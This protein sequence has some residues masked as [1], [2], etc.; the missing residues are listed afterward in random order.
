[1]P[2]ERLSVLES[3][4]N[5]QYETFLRALDEKAIELEELRRDG[6]GIQV[7]NRAELYE[8]LGVDFD[9]IARSFR[10]VVD[11]TNEFLEQLVG[12]LREKRARV[13]DVLSGDVPF[14][15]VSTSDVESLNAVIRRHDE[16]TEQFQEKLRE[17]RARVEADSVSGNLDE[18]VRLEVAMRSFES[19]IQQATSEADRLKA[20]IARLER[21]I[22]EHQKPA[23]ELNADLRNYLGYGELSLQVKETGYAITRDGVPA[24]GLSEGEVTAIALLYFLKSLQDRRFDLANAIVV[25]DDPV[26]SLDANALYLAFGLL[27]ERAQSAAQLFILT[28]N[29]R[30]FRQ[31]RNWFHHLPKQ[32]SKDITRR[33][34][35]FYMLDCEMKDGKRYSRVSALDPLLEKFESEYH[36]L[37]ARVYRAV[38]ATSPLAF[39]D[40]YVLPNIARR[41]VE[42]FLA[43]RRPD[44][45]GEL[46]QKLKTV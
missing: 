17:A 30:L 43:F 46:W 27:R 33:P 15:D 37:F 38:G 41:L 25:L 45:A 7:P 18:F 13:F 26:S 12:K 3:H 14:S 31:V 9:A 23:E 8:H 42:M 4:F 24:R 34:A 28:H 6:M 20:E 19:S 11:A 1:M 44:I 39:E 2:A 16:A 21:E 32:G 35:R 5:A 29:F 40:S 36:Y 10:K 22:V